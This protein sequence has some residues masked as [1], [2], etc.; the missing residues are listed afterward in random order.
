VHG[1]WLSDIFTG[2]NEAVEEKKVKT[3]LENLGTHIKK[4]GE[5]VVKNLKSQ[6][7]NV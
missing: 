6:T 2:L 7:P 1:S 4:L 5:D 3:N